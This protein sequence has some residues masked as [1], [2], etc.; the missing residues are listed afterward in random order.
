MIVDTPECFDCRH[1]KPR[2][3][4]PGHTCTAFPDGIPWPIL[5][6]IVLHRKPYPGDHGIQFEL[7]TPEERAAA[8]ELRRKMTEEFRARNR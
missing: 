5:K 3:T 1:Y 4:A 2:E 7:A 8:A 6:S